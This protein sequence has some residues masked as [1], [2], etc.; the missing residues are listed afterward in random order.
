[1][2]EHQVDQGSASWF[3]LRAKIPTASEFHR[4]MTPARRKPAEARWKY[5]IEIIAA[6]L[7]NWQK[8]SLDNIEHIE[9][10]KASEPL[11]VAQ[12][13]FSTGIK[14][15]P[16]GFLTTDDGRFGASP[17]RLTVPTGLGTIEIKCPTVPTHLGYL[18][19]GHD[20]AYRCQ[21]Q[22][23]L[24]VAEA[25]K[26]TFYSYHERMPPYMSESGRDTIFMTDLFASLEQ[27]SDELLGMEER[28]RTLGL[29]QKYDEI[30]PPIDLVADA[31]ASKADADAELEAWLDIAR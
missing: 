19:Y 10:G 23:Q 26:A 9:A 17:D 31:V 2:I 6:R 8:E 22:G 18:Y 16:V 12:L 30:S 27:F 13:E 11:A 3:A 4:V 14:T 25:D 28:A 1:M 7:L 15:R 24:L 5:A 20:D 21:V 29:F